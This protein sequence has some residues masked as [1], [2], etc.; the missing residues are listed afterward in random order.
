M[1][2]WERT[3]C[4]SAHF[5]REGQSIITPGHLLQ[6]HVIKPLKDILAALPSN[7]QRIAYLVEETAK[8]TG[9][10]N[11]PQYLALLFEVDALFLN[12]ES[13]SNNIAVLYQNGSY[14][15][16]SVCVVKTPFD[17][18]MSKIGC[19]VLLINYPIY[20]AIS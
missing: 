2:R 8:I 18:S 11:F 13:A 15:I 16:S 9:L 14:D 4:S 19:I 6:R 10:K 7:K 5:L 12:D 3:A 17:S 1:H 20:L